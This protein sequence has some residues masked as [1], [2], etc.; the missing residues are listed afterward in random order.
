MNYRKLG[1]W[2]IQVSELSLGSWLTFGKQISDETAKE[3]MVAAYDNGINFF[4][5]AEIYAKG[6]SEEVMGKILKDTGWARDTYVVSTK[7]FWGGDKPNQSGLSRKHIMEGINN[8]LRRMQLEYVDLFFCHRPDPNTP[9]EETVFAMN[10]VVRSGKAFYWGT[11]EWSAAEITEAHKVAR[12]YGLIAPAME[13]PQYNMVTR[14]RFEKEYANLYTEYGMGTTIWSPLA[15]GL[16]TGKYNQGKPAEDTRLNMQ[17]MEWLNERIIGE[18]D[19]A[20]QNIEKTKQLTAL[21]G[22]LG[23]SMTHLALAW[24]LKNPNVST[25]ITG[26]SKVAHLLDN[27]KAVEAVDKLTPEAMAG[28]E[29]ILQNNPLAV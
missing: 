13:Q 22:D 24:C 14:Q 25:V 6:K 9:I 15:S 28:I 10:D 12:Q 8:S 23:L 1:K 19:I 26:A 16:L 17:G 4:D 21:A 3:L 11:S 2:G 18:N 20:Q 7:V 5:N 27:L 29:G